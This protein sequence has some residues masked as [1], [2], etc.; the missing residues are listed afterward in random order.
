M[1]S[2]SEPS[3]CEIRI[4]QAQVKLQPSEAPPS[5]LTAKRGKNISRTPNSV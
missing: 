4:S 5:N 3:S 2:Y 1:T